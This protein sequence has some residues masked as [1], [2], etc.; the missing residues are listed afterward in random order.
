MVEGII[1]MLLDAVFAEANSGEAEEATGNGVDKADAQ[2]GEM[3]ENVDDHSQ[4]NIRD[5]DSKHLEPK[6]TQDGY[7]C[8]VVDC[9]DH[10]Q[11]RKRKSHVVEHIGYLHTDQMDYQ[12]SCGK[13]GAKWYKR[14]DRY[15]HELACRGLG[16]KMPGRPL[17]R[18]PSSALSLPQGVALKKCRVSVKRLKLDKKGPESQE[19]AEKPTEKSYLSQIRPHVTLE[20]KRQILALRESKSAE[21]AAKMR[22]SNS[23]PVTEVNE[24]EIGREVI[25]PVRVK[26]S[27]GR[28]KPAS[29]RGSPD[30]VTEVHEQE[31]GSKVPATTVK[32]VVPPVRARPSRVRG[33]PERLDCNYLL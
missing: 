14:H 30:P 10:S 20:A 6:F 7:I 21:F 18:P 25:Q 27:W 11:P 16:I 31:I 8:P 19:L 29:Q 12:F 3:E 24:Q 32:E 2:D 15:R 13:C 23:V 22:G 17:W 5:E 1:E 33:K 9:I 28:G 4:V 26:K